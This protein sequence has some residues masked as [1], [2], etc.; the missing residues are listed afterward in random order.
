MAKQASRYVEVQNAGT[1]ATQRLLQDQRSTAELIET[2]LPVVNVFFEPDPNDDI[3]ASYDALAVLHTRGTRDVMKEALA[4]CGSPEPMRRVLGATI[5]GGL[6]SPHRSYPEE[7][8]DALLYIV[9]HEHDLG[10]LSAAISALG[11]LR[12][13]RCEPALIPLK[14]HPSAEI[15]DCVAFA[16]GGS[17]NPASVQALL[18]LMEDPSKMARSWATV[19]IGRTVSVDGLEFRAALLRRAEDIDEF[20]R[21][22]ALYGLA[23]RHDMRVVP[24]LISEL[25]IDHEEEHPFCDAA[26]AFLG[27]DEKQDVDPEELIT[28]LRSANREH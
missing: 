6:G 12:N 20:T 22:E 18:E 2:A 26:K 4:L 7:C 24:L 16:L 3:F 25:Q 17:E 15:R 13:R 28:A 21:A 9:R 19:S 5:L 10:V 27:M 11:D 23:S 8:C 1:S 14:I